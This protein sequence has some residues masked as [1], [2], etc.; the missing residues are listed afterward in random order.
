MIATGTSIAMILG[1]PLGRLVGLIAGWRLT[2]FLIGAIS[3]VAFL[4]LGKFFPDLS[5][6]QA[7]TLQELPAILKNLVIY[8]VFFM[9]LSFATAY[10]T[11]YSYVEPYLALARCVDPDNKST[12]WEG[13]GVASGVIAPVS[14]TLAALMPIAAVESE[15]IPVVVGVVMTA[16]CL[17]IGETVIRKQA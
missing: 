17:V 2:F 12:S 11:S 9:S 8:G 5:N 3:F 13:F 14:S 15:W 4:Y 10:Y 1:L 6:G 7:F 16:I